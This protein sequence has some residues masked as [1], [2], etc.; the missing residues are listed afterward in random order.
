MVQSVIIGTEIL[1]L[2]VVITTASVRNSSVITP[3]HQKSS[4]NHLTRKII[5]I[6]SGIQNLWR[7]DNG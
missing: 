6:W 4:G 1:K 5:R 7:F 3:E 2:S